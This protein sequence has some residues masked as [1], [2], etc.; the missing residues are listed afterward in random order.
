MFTPPNNG[1][2]AFAGNN[3]IRGY[4]T[5]ARDHFGGVP[6]NSMP[7]MTGSAR[8]HLF[9]SAN[10]APVM[11]FGGESARR[12]PDKSF[13]ERHNAFR[14][15]GTNNVPQGHPFGAP[16][17]TVVTIVDRAGVRVAKGLIGKIFTLIEGSNS[18][19]Y[20]HI[21]V[22]RKQFNVTPATIQ[23][24][25][26][27]ATTFD[28]SESMFS[29]GTTRIAKAKQFGTY[30]AM[31]ASSAEWLKEFANQMLSAFELTIATMCYEAL[32]AV[33][34]PARCIAEHGVHMDPTTLTVSPEDFVRM[35][36][37]EAELFGVVNKDPANA[38]HVLLAAADRAMEN[39][40]HRTT[41]LMVGEAMQYRRM[42]LPIPPVSEVGEARAEKM[43][44]GDPIISDDL[45]SRG[46][47]QM[48]V[49][50]NF[51]GSNRR[52]YDPFLKQMA[53]GKF[54]TTPC[55]RTIER[56]GIEYRRGSADPTI[57][58]YDADSY[59]TLSHADA[60]HASGLLSV[61]NDAVYTGMAALFAASVTGATIGDWY[62]QSDV[63][64]V[65]INILEHVLRSTDAAT[66]GSPWTG[67][68]AG[69]GAPGDVVPAVRVGIADAAG[70][71][72]A[73]FRGLSLRVL[74]TK[75]C[76]N[77]YQNNHIPY[78]VSL[79]CSRFGIS[80][81]TENILAIDA[82]T[83]IGV[84]YSTGIDSITSN[85]INQY[86]TVL[87]VSHTGAGVVD[88]S[89]VALL[90]N[91]F[92]RAYIGG[93]NT[94]M[95]DNAASVASQRSKE[96]GRVFD[97]HTVVVPV[98]FKQLCAV[99]TTRV[100]TLSLPGFSSEAPMVEIQQ[101]APAGVTRP[102]F[103]PSDAICQ[104]II[105]R[106]FGDAMYADGVSHILGGLGRDSVMDCLSATQG[107]QRAPVVRNLS[108]GET[109][110]TTRCVHFGHC[111]HP[112]VFS[113]LVKGTP[114]TADA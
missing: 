52:P 15:Q 110:R 18:F 25:M 64:P 34:T 57:I 83:P 39:S 51:V 37:E 47:E 91:P 16:G 50:R 79:V 41:V 22:R 56:M 44:S 94:R 97:A 11:T 10:Q 28:D 5:N 21:E 53:L 77:W 92:V 27:T 73:A 88:P 112:D 93:G 17:A 90:A 48:I 19:P 66:L 68:V 99:Q 101:T 105:D 86:G 32:L 20:H 36:R 71:R 100:F 7:S 2:T 45:T 106:Y 46:V 42:G 107:F 63:P 40:S 96:R 113:R 61:A 1:R 114:L 38:A 98:T 75:Q 9:S 104:F 102:D 108:L 12:L 58:D 49:P 80:V 33:Y 43:R 13:R 87:C 103:M 65:A 111:P 55:W 109:E 67:G 14:T 6:Q 84:V 31:E 69:Q 54:C 85:S 8:S 30:W 59:A 78:P 4:G 23:P 60:I 70:D 76:F 81:A 74:F 24:D 95:L 26:G 72:V 3:M 82:T 35:R 89:A 29:I 62:A